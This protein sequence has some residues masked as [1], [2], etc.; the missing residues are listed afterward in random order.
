MSFDKDMVRVYNYN[1]CGV[2]LRTNDRS[3]YLRGTDDVNYPTMETLTFKELEYVNTHSLAI[4]NGFVEFAEEEREELYKALHC[5][6][7]KDTCIFERDIDKMLV[8][9][10]FETMKKVVDVKDLFTIDRIYAHMRKLM[11]GNSVDVSSRVQKVVTVRRNELR[12]GIM[13]SKIQ[14]ISKKTEQPKFELTAEEL[15]QLIKEQVAAQM[16]AHNA[17]AEGEVVVHDNESQI[18]AESAANVSTEE[19]EKAAPAKRTTRTTKTKAK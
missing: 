1:A 10:T 8:S 7:W 13:T 4:R 11:R 19:K 15:N 12:E 3:I 2:A 6:N 17:V 16:G 5:S 9:A 14:L 18:V